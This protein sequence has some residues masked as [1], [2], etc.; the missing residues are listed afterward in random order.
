M[1]R[2]S[3]VALAALAVAPQL[4][5]AQSYQTITETRR[6]DAGR[7]LKV[8]V[9]FAAGHLTMR[10]ADDQHRYHIGL[11]YVEDVFDPTVAYDP[12][13]GTLT[14]RLEGHG[15]R[16]IKES[17]TWDQ[18]LD[19]DLPRDVP[20]DLAMTLGAV[21]GDIDLGDLTLRSASIKT[22]ASEAGVGFSSPTRGACERLEF[23][24]G[25]S[26]FEANQIG[27]SGC[28]SISLKGGVGQM[29]LDF[30]GDAPW[31]GEMHVAIQ[32]GLGD[33]TL[34]VPE[35]VGIRLDA[36]RFLATISKAHLAKRGSSY[37][38]ANFDSASTRLVIDVD[39]ALGNVEIQRID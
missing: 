3:L 23:E 11:K 26:Q 13:E 12:A 22:G 10:P 8:D 2:V 31:K 5:V 4:A 20:V 38:S 36:T 14:V 34:R 33:V 19:L 21:K 7:P 30:R 39:A 18:Q 27:N 24:V 9:T 37:Y 32:V 25:A 28:R 17:D 15:H 16:Q 29:V 35:A 6:V 1:T